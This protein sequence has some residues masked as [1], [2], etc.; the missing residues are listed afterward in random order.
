MLKHNFIKF[1]IGAGVLIATFGLYSVAHAA[2]SE[3]YHYATSTP[4]CLNIASS[5]LIWSSGSACGSGGGN[6]FAFPFSPQSWGNSTSTTLGFLNGFLSTA[7]STQ[8][9]PFRLTTTANGL[10]ASGVDGLV[11]S[12]ATGT[13][14][15]TGTVSCGAGS[16]VVGANLT[17][18][19]SAGGGG[20][21]P[22]TPVAGGNSTSTTLFLYNG[23][24]I[25]NNASSTIKYAST[26]S[27]TSS[28]SAYFATAGGNVGIGITA[29]E[30]K[31]HVSSSAVSNGITV[32][33]AGSTAMQLLIGYNTSGDYGAIQ[34]IHQNTG[35]T[36][37]VLNQFGG[38]V[39]V[40]TT[41]P[42]AKLAVTGAGTGTGITLQTANS[43]NVPNLTVYDNGTTTMRADAPFGWSYT[44]ENTALT[45]TIRGGGVNPMAFRVNSFSADDPVF[46]FAGN[47]N[48]TIVTIRNG[49][50]VGI[51]TT[52]PS[53]VLSVQGNTIISGNIT[54]VANVTATGTLTV[55][56]LTSAITLTNGSGVFAEYAGTSCTNQFVRSLS[57]LGAATCA[58]VGASDVSLAN[59][60]AT[61]STLT[62]SGTYNG[63]TARTIG[64]NLGNT[65]TWTALQQ[66]ASHA[67][68]T[69]VSS[70]GPVYVG[71]TATTTVRGDNGTSTFSGGIQTTTL[72]VTSTTATTTFANGIQLSG[73]C[74]R[75][76]DG[77][78][79]INSAGG[80][81]TI[82]TTYATST[83]LTTDSFCRNVSMSASQTLMIWGGAGRGSG[84]QGPLDIQKK[85][86]TDLATSTVF[87]QAN[88]T[89]H[90]GGW[91]NIF[92]MLTSTSTANTVNVCV[93][94]NTGVAFSGGASIMIQ[95]F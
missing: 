50:N 33:E 37:L 24:Y 27:I 55:A 66:F 68:T 44:D 88:A 46:T 5:G 25:N 56:P 52:T 20:D 82:S 62:F 43:S 4:G 78:C 65:N 41:T 64:L 18:N 11:Y 79:V 49:G 81:S 8:N 12:T 14:T 53:Q 32:G 3:I 31:L 19:G 72:D 1:I 6:S 23:L 16:Y 95:Q 70:Y 71:G 80:G 67:S 94:G 9:G 48:T 57:A 86:A 42:L 85:F 73:G 63:S 91:S 21:F 17:I 92:G 10:L 34:A 45:H 26:T 36:P 87:T 35:F 74:Y 2:P 69:Q 39:G 84:A 51:G 15:C 77:N 30:T 76:V 83:G 47:T 22:F 7:S 40:G 58:T 89:T 61:D 13:V 59:L 90:A 38:N 29:P 60:T 28:G 75:G 93:T 54:S